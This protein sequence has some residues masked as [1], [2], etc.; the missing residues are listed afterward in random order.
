MQV[1]FFIQ[2]QFNEICIRNLE[3]SPLRANFFGRTFDLVSEC[4]T[5]YAC[6]VSGWR[7]L[8]LNNSLGAR[9]VYVRMHW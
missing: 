3:N 7:S 6:A 8:A 1:R 9:P 2:S 5:F 4:N